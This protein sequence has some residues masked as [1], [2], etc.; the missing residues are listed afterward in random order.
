MTLPTKFVGRFEQHLAE[1]VESLLTH[2]LRVP[3]TLKGMHCFARA[4]SEGRDGH[5]AARAI[6]H[7]RE[8]IAY[9][10]SAGTLTAYRGR[11]LQRALIRRRI[12]DATKLGCRVMIGGADFE[13]ESRTN[14]MACGLTV[15][16]L[17]AVWTQRADAMLGLTNRSFP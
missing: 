13:N 4:R 17:A 7:W 11:G 12:A 14:Q 9:L 2:S 1:A 5:P 3:A 15:A 6:L 16:Y 10:E 8:E